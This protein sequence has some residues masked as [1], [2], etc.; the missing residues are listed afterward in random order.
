MTI[1]YIISAYKLPQLLVRLV[2]RL[3]GP[4]TRFYVHVDART[5]GFE[6]DG[7]ARP[8]ADRA[9]VRFLPRHACYWGDY[10]H[11]RASLA[12]LRAALDN[13]PFDYAVLLTGQDYPI[14]T[15]TRIARTLGGSE[16]A[17]FMSHFA[18]P[19]DLWTDGGLDRIEHRQLRI[20]RRSY[21]F[22][23]QPFGT[24]L[25]GG[26]WSTWTRLL[27]LTRTFPQPLRPYG[28]SSYW[29]MPADCAAYAVRFLADN[30]GVERFFRQTTVPDEMVFQTIV[31]NSSFGARVVND[32][33]RYIDWT[34]GDHHPG[35]LDSASFDTLIESGK[36]FA[37]K[38]DPEV[39]S[40]ILDR[41]D[42]YLDQ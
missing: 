21:R 26:A 33:L 13:G 2:R 39:D 30:P 34:A 15:N 37:R 11:V 25:L 5:A 12:G 41:I 29:S 24:G 23:G 18:L 28:G 42:A 20:G 17:I 32:D 14:A 1:A 38:F 3:D 4:T 36:L 19:S 22:P 10:G 40:V 27:R 9:N 31:M 16:G 7:M 8:L 35:V 6:F